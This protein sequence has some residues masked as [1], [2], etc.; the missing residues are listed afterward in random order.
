[1]A[2]ED[3]I[4]VPSYAEDESFR[5]TRGR[6]PIFMKMSEAMSVLIKRD[7]PTAVNFNVNLLIILE[8]GRSG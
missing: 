1:M 8:E 5:S 7:C 3:L 4:S 6:E 2:Q